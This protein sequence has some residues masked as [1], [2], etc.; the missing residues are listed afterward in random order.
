M[1]RFYVSHPVED[2]EKWKPLFDAD[3]ERHK[4][5]GLTT[6]GVYRQAGDENNLLIVFEGN[7]PEVVRK[8][9]S[10][11]ELGEKMKEAGVLGPPEAFAGEKL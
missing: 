1:A 8:M 3:A 6:V 11:P 4:D 5:A 10:D 2:F 9:L 7:D